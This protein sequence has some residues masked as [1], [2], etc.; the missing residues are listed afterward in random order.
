MA[1]T[2]N[3]KETTEVSNYT[4]TYGI[5]QFEILGVNLPYK[6]LKELGFYVKEEDLE[7]D[8][9]FT[10]EVEGHA[11]VQ[12]EFACRDFNKPERLKRFSFWLEDVEVKTKADNPV[13]KWQFINAQGRCSW[14]L[15]PTSFV[16]EY[17]STFFTGVDDAYEPRPAKKGEEEFMAF[18]RAAM[19][20][21]YKEG[22][23]IRYNVKKLF[24]G[25]VKEIQ[26]DLNTDFLGTV[27]IATVIRL[28]QTE[29]GLKEIETFY[30]RAFA[31]GD[32]YKLLE[33]KKSYS[34]ADI[35]AVHDKIANNFGK[36]GKDRKY[37]T[38]LEE[39]IAKI[40][41]EKYPCKDVFH[42]GM[43]KEYKSGN[44]IEASDSAIITED[45]YESAGTDNDDDNSSMY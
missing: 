40:T 6:K 5:G 24:A 18:M 44:H 3:K 45:D 29:E 30:S 38:P 22:G 10:G 33:T 32:S 23:T 36:K 19:R 43:I 8:R 7:K 21:N 42:I 13:E 31:P 28:K 20:I 26:D 27:L 1:I 15:K 25:N 4:K 2:G 34:D 37:V 12:L 35:K 17:D 41:D 9:D 14:S 39:L 16:T 11:K